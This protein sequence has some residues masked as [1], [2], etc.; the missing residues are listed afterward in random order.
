MVLH[1][2]LRIF[3]AIILL[4]AVLSFFTFTEH[5]NT[6]D[7]GAILNEQLIKDKTILD[8]V[9]SEDKVNISLYTSFTPSAV[10]IRIDFPDNWPLERRVEFSNKILKELSFKKSNINDSILLEGS[11][12]SYDENYAMLSS[13]ILVSNNQHVFHKATLYP[14]VGFVYVGPTQNYRISESSCISYINA[15]FLFVNLPYGYYASDVPQIVSRHFVASKTFEDSKSAP[16]CII[17][18]YA[19]IIFYSLKTISIKLSLNM[20]VYPGTGGIIRN[21]GDMLIL[22]RN[23]P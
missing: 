21:I 3:L 11:R 17:Y 9:T 2:L 18:D 5:L 12:I 4:L 16:S 7:T 14:V 23:V 1:K 22:E 13:S 6:S 10:A 15:L 19:P 8:K 20:S